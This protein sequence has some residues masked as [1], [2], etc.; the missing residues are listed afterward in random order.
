[1]VTDNTAV[2]R[3]V[4]G[5]LPTCHNYWKKVLFSPFF[6]DC[7]NFLVF[8]NWELIFS[9]ESD[10]V[11][12]RSIPGSFY[13]RLKIFWTLPNT[14][15]KQYFENDQSWVSFGKWR[16]SLIKSMCWPSSQVSE[17]CLLYSVAPEG[18]R[19]VHFP[20]PWSYWNVKN[21]ILRSNFKNDKNTWYTWAI[22]L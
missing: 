15:E 2:E 16:D 17:W 13:D 7:Y 12:N 20:C 19:R 8:Q 3:S 4:K 18:M 9:H 5:L 21:S 22:D 1:M 6:S 14:A 10:L 11:L